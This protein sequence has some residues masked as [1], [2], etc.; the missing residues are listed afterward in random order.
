MQEN[1]N[2]KKIMSQWGMLLV[3]I[4]LAMVF[5]MLNNGY[6]K[7]RDKISESQ[8]EQGKNLQE[9]IPV[10]EGRHE[11]GGKGEGKE[12]AEGETLED[13]KVDNT[14]QM[15]EEMPSSDN[16][17][18]SA[19]DNGTDNTVDN[20]SH[21][22]ADTAVE[23]NQPEFVQAPEGYFDDALF[24]GDSRTVGLSE[25]GGIEGADFFATTGM[26]VYNIDGERVRLDDKGI[27]AF[28]SLIT[29]NTYG[30]IY[31]MLGIN[32]LGYN[33]DKTIEVYKN[34]VERIR[35]AQPEAVIFIEANLHVSGRRSDQ[36]AI[37]NN[38]NID[39]INSNI[40]ALADNETTFYID[41][42]VLFDD[43]NG[44]LRED[45]TVDDSHILGRYYK[46]WAD[47]LSEKAIIR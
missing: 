9:S 47:W 43:E 40:S 3:V 18:D 29:Q 38:Q 44:N 27:I 41:V 12:T 8:E 42:N 23:E 30:K 33:M 28:D 16:V 17:E 21:N 5:I 26:S 13:T 11:N 37:Y 34:L 31:L 25:Y 46:Q 45:I 35:Q 20:E 36:D 14:E 22:A 19:E 1:K 39:Y 32:E 7:F 10:N 2:I 24:I 15:S 6:L 4:I